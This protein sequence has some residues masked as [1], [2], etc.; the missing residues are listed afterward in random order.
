MYVDQKKLSCNA[1]HQEV[2]NCRTRGEF[3][4]ATMGSN[5]ALKTRTD[6]TRNP[7]QRY[8][9]IQKRNLDRSISVSSKF[10]NESYPSIQRELCHFVPMFLK[11]VCQQNVFKLENKIHCGQYENILCWSPFWSLSGIKITPLSGFG[12][13]FS[14]SHSHFFKQ[15]Q[16][17]YVKHIQNVKSALHLLLY[18]IDM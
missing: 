6:V 13:S 15:A 12:H 17:I 14:F 4:D 10:S 1:D 7:K 8:Q 16:F 11:K 5:L 3:E 2:S 9:W 18:Y